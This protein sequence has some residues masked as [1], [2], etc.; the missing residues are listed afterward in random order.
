MKALIALYTP[1]FTTTIVYML[2]STEYQLVPYL[3]WF[4]RTQ[5]FG[6]VMY[7]RTLNYTRVARALLL[8]VRAG[9][10]S[11]IILGICLIVVSALNDYDELI[12]F[13]IAIVLFAPILWAHLMI[14]PI[15]LG[16]IFITKPRERRLIAA[17]EKIFNDFQGV[18]IAV[19]GSYGKTT[20]KELLLTVLSEGKKVAATPGNRN[21]TISHARFAQKLEGDEDVIIIEYGEGQPGDVAKF[22]AYT[23]PQKVIITGIAPAHLDK[24]KILAAAAED[25]FS[26]TKD[27]EASDV[28]ANSDSMEMQPYIKDSFNT[29]S[30]KGG[31][32]WKVSDVQMSISGMSFKLERDK[33]K[34][35]LQT[36]LLGEH[37]IGPLVLVVAL[38]YEL[39]LTPEQIE[40]GIAKTK[41]YEHRMQPYQLGGAWVIDDS[42]NGNIEGIRAGTELLAKLDA[43]RKV[44]VT[45]GLVDQ[46]KETKRVHEEIGRLIAKSKPDEVVLM[47]NSVTF[48]IQSGLAAGKYTGKITVIDKPLDF[49]NNLEHFVAA[50]DIIML[51]NDWPDNYR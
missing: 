21:V 32:G 28:Y 13:G 20:V 44:Y 37:L 30:H 51:Q 41:P 10:Y 35:Q 11:Q 5:N 1:R 45:P 34:L 14:A 49:Y 40:A 23:T 38:A 17:S 8:L 33:V 25:I 31:M 7:R 50:G 6:R 12:Y 15:I 36:G 3:A 4:W 39:G 16:R 46:G 19:A 27:V 26:A 18:K 42:Y 2:Q 29:Y 48:H 9:M 43:K 24:Y 47:Q 22:A